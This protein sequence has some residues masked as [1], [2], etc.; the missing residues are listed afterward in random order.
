VAAD[1]IHRQGGQAADSASAAIRLAQRGLAHAAVILHGDA[2]ALMGQSFQ[3][4]L[5]VSGA[6]AS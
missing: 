2:G 1:H 6:M 5:Q 3:G 4:R